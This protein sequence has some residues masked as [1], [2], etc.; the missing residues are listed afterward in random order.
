[1]ISNK[2]H[3]SPREDG[4]LL[5]DWLDRNAAKIRGA[6]SGAFMAIVQEVSSESFR[7]GTKEACRQFHQKL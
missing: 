2:R 4:E 7:A 6:T 5:T 3:L 1:M